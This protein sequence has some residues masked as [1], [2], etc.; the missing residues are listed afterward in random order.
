MKISIGNDGY[1][2]PGTSP[3]KMSFSGSYN[4]ESVSSSRSYVG[5]F[6][7][8]KYRNSAKNNK[9]FI[10]YFWGDTIRPNIMDLTGIANSKNT[11]VLQK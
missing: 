3:N 2:Q 9:Q 10:D 1:L 7:I 8:D 11:V 5:Q 4:D 6:D